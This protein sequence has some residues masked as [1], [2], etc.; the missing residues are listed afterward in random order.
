MYCFHIIRGRINELNGEMVLKGTSL[1]ALKA[2]TKILVLDDDGFVFM[3]PLR[4]SEFCI[5]YRQ[6]IQA[7]SDVAE[8]DIILCDIRGVGAFLDSQYEGAYLVKKIKEKYPNKIVISYTASDYSPSYQE[9]L[10]YADAIIP[11]GTSLEDWD[12]LLTE[13]IRELADPVKM[14][15]KTREALLKANVQTITVAEYESQYVK[16]IQNN[17]FESIKK[18]FE[19]KKKPGTEIMLSLLTSVIAKVIEKAVL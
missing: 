13:K 14:W 9:Y 5:E 7:L 12:S 6:D 11:K 17:S 19:K 18:L 3:E 15:E 10:K 16:A 1:P 8:Y 2:I 4:R